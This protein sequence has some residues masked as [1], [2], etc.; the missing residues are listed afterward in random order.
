MRKFQNNTLRVV[1][2]LVMLA[3]ASLGVN[4]SHAENEEKIEFE[5]IQYDLPGD[6]PSDEI[7]TILTERVVD[8]KLEVMELVLPKDITDEDLKRILSLEETSGWSYLKYKSYQSGIVLFDGKVSKNGDKYWKI[9]VNGTLDLSKG[10]LDL[11][12]SG[13]SNGADTKLTKSPSQENLDYRVIFSG[14]M[15]E[16]DKENVFAYAFM[17]S[18]QIPEVNQNLKL[19]QFGN[20]TSESMDSEYDQKVRN[21]GLVI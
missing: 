13:K 17:N 3:T 9:S 12:L 6:S 5:E 11:K 2:L 8:G 21:S 15:A 4:Y 18:S 16:S 14:K 19:L 7:R 20:L 1:T 10:K